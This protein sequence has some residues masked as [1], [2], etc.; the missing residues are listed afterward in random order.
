MKIPYRHF[1]KCINSNININQ[2]SE[3][4][5]QLGHEHE[6]YDDIFDFEITPNRGD[7]I[8]L[9]GML[10]D[11][12]LFYDVS[13]DKCIYEKEIESFDFQFVNDAKDSCTSISFLKIDIDELPKKYLGSLEEYFL[14]LE[15]KKINFFTD[16]SNFISYETG[17]PTHCYDSSK[18]NG[19][20]RL[21][22]LKESFEFETLLDKKINVGEGDLAFTN[23]DNEVINLAGIIGGKSSS[24]DTDTKSVI[25][26]CAYFDPEAIIGKSVKYDINSDAAYKFERNTD[27]QCHEYVIKRFLKIVEDH[28]TIKNVKLFQKTYKKRDEILIPFNFEKINKILGTN[29]EENDCL[30]FL[31]KLGFLITNNVI[32][33][34]SFRNDINSLNDISEEIAR[35]VG[36]N[37]I[38][39]KKI[40]IDVKKET[41]INFNETKLK[42]LLINHGFYEV[43]N[44]PFVGE[45]SNESVQV[46]NPLDSNKNYLRTNLK[47]SLT[48]NLLFNE[49]RQKDIIKLFEVSDLYSSENKIGKKVI[50]II[51]SGRI[52][53]NFKDFSKKIDKK[54]LEKV[55]RNI[56]SNDIKIEEISRQSLN[57]KSKDIITYT[58]IEIDKIIDVQSTYDDLTIKG[59]R[60]IKY[61]PISEFPSSNRDLSFSIKDF[62]ECKKLEELLINF[63]NKLLKD[64]FVFDYYRNENVGEIKIGFRFIFQS[65]DST[66]TD[67]EV[68]KVMNLVISDALKIKTVS[69]P[70]LK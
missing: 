35:A 30:T 51:A 25:V 15:V 26:E 31:N 33:V 39:S 43:I 9:N 61:E 53:K 47:D 64:V 70:G 50:G 62:S 66:I 52:D 21:K 45:G 16:I 54:Y 10:R 12:N 13:K 65:R 27:Y 19:P 7:C 14:D 28:T 40:N 59:I 22:F 6:I 49:R 41:Q 5:F 44:N 57:S 46:D 55:L 17:Q 20:L 2:L 38:K 37:N 24:C 42:K 11:L 1:K 69:I 60:D 68:N 18:I 4:F 48:T 3:S 67:D 23:T 29:I 58:E 36:Y 56:K 63:E 32:H 34:P 8:S